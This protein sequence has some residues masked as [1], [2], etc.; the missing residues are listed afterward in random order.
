MINGNKTC[1]SINIR[2][3]AIKCLKEISTFADVF[4]FTAGIK[5]YAETIMD[6][7]DKKKQYIS[8][9]LWRNDW[10]FDK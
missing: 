5:S 10:I 6:Y 1:A 7:L 9:W 2:P 3:N 8:Y 4:I